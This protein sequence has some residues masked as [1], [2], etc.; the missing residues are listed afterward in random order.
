[1]GGVFVVS[2]GY[3]RLTSV[4]T[5]PHPSGE[6]RGNRCRCYGC[7]IHVFEPVS[8]FESMALAGTEQL[9]TGVMHELEVSKAIEKQ[10]DA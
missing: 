2:G 6:E 1:M 5:S 4:K 3:H 8:S 7:G 10:D 9:H